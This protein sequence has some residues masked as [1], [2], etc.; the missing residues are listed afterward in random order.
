MKIRTLL[1]LSLLIFGITPL[2]V[3]GV[4]TSKYF[5]DV[6]IEKELKISE[7]EID[8][9]RI[10]IET[11]LQSNISD[12]ITLSKIS[13][14]QQ[15]VNSQDKTD[16]QLVKTALAQDFL[17]MAQ[18][19]KY[20]QI[21][22]LD[23]EGNEIIRIDNIEGK[24]TRIPEE[25]L[26]NKADRYYFQQAIKLSPGKIYVS[27]LDL[28][29]ENDKL[30][31]VG[32]QENPIYVPVIRY[33]IPIFDDQLQSKGIIITN[34]YANSFFNFL[35]NNEV[36][37]Q[38]YLV[39]EDGY[40]LYHPLES[41]RF[42]NQIEKLNANIFFEFDDF[43]SYALNFNYKEPFLTNNNYIAQ[44]I[45]ITPV[46]FDDVNKRIS[47]N[48]DNIINDANSWSLVKI[49]KLS[50]IEEYKKEISQ[51][52]ALIVGIALLIIIVSSYF[53]SLIITKPID[54]IV[55]F[56]EQIDG[57]KNNSLKPNAITKEIKTLITNI[58]KM[59]SSLHEKREKIEQRVQERTEELEKLNKIMINREIKMIEI[60]KKLKAQTKNAN[61]EKK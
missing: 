25:K 43:A 9:K 44:R 53:G 2:L 54:E 55:K 20:Y 45:E 14:L 40:Y 17:S 5:Y 37:S 3:S 11:S 30:Q 38:F 31:N 47:I 27:K 23:E 19:K 21:R 10:Q 56:I 26:Q 16:R 39:D 1:G 58:N 8:N 29:I 34:V 57:N 48:S 33:A 22:Y 59:N 12:L 6:T 49:T 35:S 7:K 50:K 15:L 42:G 4:F 36:D 41:M 32:T 61:D 60:K 24:A 28:N 18:N 52:L 51:T 13:N 46:S